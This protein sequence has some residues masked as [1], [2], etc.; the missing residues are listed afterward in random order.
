M[1]QPI[2]VVRL[3]EENVFRIGNDID[4]VLQDCNITMSIENHVTLPNAVLRI[5]FAH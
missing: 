5:N 3:L 4:Q 2:H 1:V